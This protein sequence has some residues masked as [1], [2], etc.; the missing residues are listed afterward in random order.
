MAK[1]T[2]MIETTIAP[3]TYPEIVTGAVGTGY[4]M[5]FRGKSEIPFTASCPRCNRKSSLV[6]RG[7]EETKFA[8]IH[9]CGCGYRKFFPTAIKFKDVSN[10]KKAP[11]CAKCNNPAPKGRK[12]CFTCWPKGAKAPVSPP[13]QEPAS[14]KA[15]GIVM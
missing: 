1:N 5:V 10:S 14:E 8:T 3:K 15:T 2:E 7:N 9:A 6:F 13:A 4:L 11:T 12:H